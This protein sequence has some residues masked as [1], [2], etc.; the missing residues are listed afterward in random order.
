MIVYL[1]HFYNSSRVSECVIRPQ[2][3]QFVNELM[4]WGRIV[5]RPF[6]TH[7]SSAG[8][9]QMPFGDAGASLVLAARENPGSQQSF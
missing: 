7:D 5:D 9:E 2:S 4:L 1:G 8:A 6:H 3:Q